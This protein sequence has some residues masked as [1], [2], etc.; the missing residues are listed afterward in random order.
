[1]TV[2]DVQFDPLDPLD[3]ASSLAGAISDGITLPTGAAGAAIVAP[4]PTRVA[5]WNTIA[6]RQ[7]GVGGAMITQ[8]CYR[9]QRF[10][11]YRR[12]CPVAA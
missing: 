5:H 4:P 12:D 11:H 2:L 1:V 9:C 8:R 3:H 7:G 10:G 6:P